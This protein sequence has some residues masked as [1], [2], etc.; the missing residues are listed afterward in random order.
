MV[1]KIGLPPNFDSKFAGSVVS[2]DD[3]LP[4][5]LP[6]ENPEKDTF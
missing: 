4:F 3:I 6:S 1:V 5:S 2:M